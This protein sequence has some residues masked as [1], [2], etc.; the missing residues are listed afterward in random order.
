MKQKFKITLPQD[1]EIICL[2][3][4]CD[5][6]KVLQDYINGIS[7]PKTLTAHPDDP[8]GE[9][10]NLFLEYTKSQDPTAVQN[11]MIKFL[12]KAG[13]DNEL[14][15]IAKLEIE[16]PELEAKTRVVI[17]KWCV[18]AAEFRKTLRTKTTDFKIVGH[19]N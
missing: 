2:V 3:L 1:F 12:K 10:I 16:Q 4:S 8:L 5:P 13:Y 17:D 15:E 6:A 18:R 9:N 14:K 7:I 19:D 11:K